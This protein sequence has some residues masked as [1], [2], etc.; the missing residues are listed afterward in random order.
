ML[1]YIC[2]KTTNPQT[3]VL[4]YKAHPGTSRQTLEVDK[5]D[6]DQLTQYRYIRPDDALS[7]FCNALRQT[8]VFRTHD[9][10]AIKG[11]PAS[12]VVVMN[13]HMN[14]IAGSTRR[15]AGNVIIMDPTLYVEVASELS[16]LGSLVDVHVNTAMK[17][18]EVLIAYRGKASDTDGGAGY[19]YDATTG[20]HV[21]VEHGPADLN[22]YQL[23]RFD[24]DFHQPINL[25]W[26]R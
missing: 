12:A 8:A 10:T 23:V 7:D 15:G 19:F 21:I 6:T 2:C 26:T 17:P 22:Y 13:F 9:G 16:K 20:E 14:D 4:R 18:G 1:E 11:N 25:N 24:F 5:F 3:Y